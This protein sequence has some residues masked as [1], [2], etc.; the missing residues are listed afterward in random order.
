LPSSFPDSSSG[1]GID[2]ELKSPGNKELPQELPSLRLLLLLQEEMAVNFIMP[3]VNPFSFLYCNSLPICK[4]TY[5]AFS[6]PCLS[7]LPIFKL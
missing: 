5:L 3:E 6:S 4:T 1:G 2:E 7:I